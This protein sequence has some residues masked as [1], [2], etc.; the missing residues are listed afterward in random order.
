MKTQPKSTGEWTVIPLSNGGNTIVDPQDQDLGQF[1]W[2]SNERGRVIRKVEGTLVKLHKVVAERMGISSEVDHANG[3]TLDNRRSNLRAATRSENNSNR[4][5]FSSGTP[6]SKY[7]GV[8]FTHGKWAA[9]IQKDKE[10]K[11]L[12]Y[13]KHEDSAAKAYDIA[14]KE[15]HGEFAVLN[16]PDDNAAL[17]AAKA[18]GWLSQKAL[19]EYAKI[20][21]SVEELKAEIERLLQEKSTLVDALEWYAEGLEASRAI[22]ALAKIKDGK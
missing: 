22:V 9:S 8:Q 1:K 6:A 18:G 2:S 11:W 21:A 20:E 10:R 15:L 14:A 7:K 3:N 13:F 12:G 17:A 5:K 19:D 16:F 4:Q